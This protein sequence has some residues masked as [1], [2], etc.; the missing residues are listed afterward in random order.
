MLESTVSTFDV[1]A[2]TAMDYYYV[3]NKGDA[4]GFFIMNDIS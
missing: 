4:P 3:G 2:V 1:P